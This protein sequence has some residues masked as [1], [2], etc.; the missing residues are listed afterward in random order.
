MAE[1][2]RG[3]KSSTLTPESF[4][5][6]LLFDRLSAVCTFVTPGDAWEKVTR[7]A[8]LGEWVMKT[9]HNRAD[10]R[11]LL[12]IQKCKTSIITVLIPM[13][14]LLTLMCVSFGG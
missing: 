6:L 3:T 12:I 1:H 14:C 7:H 8:P 11:A 2:L 13:C 5:I 9:F 10:N 4:C